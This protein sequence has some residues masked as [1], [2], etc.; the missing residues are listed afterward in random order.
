[1][2]PNPPDPGSYSINVSSGDVPAKLVS[3]RHEVVD[4]GIE[5]YQRG[6]LEMRVERG[7]FINNLLQSEVGFGDVYQVKDY[8]WNDPDPYE[9]QHPYQDAESEPG[10][11]SGHLTREEYPT[12]LTITRTGLSHY[13]SLFCFLPYQSEGP[14]PSNSEY[15]I[16][17]Q[18]SQTPT[19]QQTT[20]GPF[21]GIIGSAKVLF[22]DRVAFTGDSPDAPGSRLFVGMRFAAGAIAQT[23]YGYSPGLTTLRGDYHT[24]TELK[25]SIVLSNSTLELPLWIN[26]TD[27]EQDPYISYIHKYQNHS[28]ENWVLTATK[29]WPYATTSGNDAWDISTGRATNGGPGA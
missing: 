1:M 7:M 11:W 21:N 23:G 29:W 20:G 17:V 16:D 10:I 13:F 3:N 27:P 9:T 25:L 12:G 8:E 18:Y 19:E 6:L 14:I 15:G 4:P 2:D 5:G 24:A 22:L 26:G 28:G